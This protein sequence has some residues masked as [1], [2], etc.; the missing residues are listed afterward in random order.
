MNGFSGEYESKLDGKGRMILPARLKAKLPEKTP[1]VPDV[2]LVRGFEPC[3]VVYTYSVWKEVFEKVAALNEFNEAFRTFQR[4]FLR[5][6]TELELDPNGRL[7]LPR[8]MRAYAGLEK[9]V[10][11]V[12]LG[13]R[14]ELWEPTRYEAHLLQDAS[15]LSQAA[16][17]ILGDKREEF[18][19]KVNHN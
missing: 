2:V 19:I 13:N 8:L 4:S 11:V 1:D 3:L 14:M 16:E 17:A 15:A 6:C 10:V 5:G 18:I 12:G 7:L 9:E